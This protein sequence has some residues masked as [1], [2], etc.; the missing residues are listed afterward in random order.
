MRAQQQFGE[1]DQPGA[2][3]T[4]LVFGVGAQHRRGPLVALRLDVL[5]PAALVLLRVDPPRDLPR[6][7]ARLVQLQRLHH[8]LDQP[9]LVV[10]V[11]YLETLRQLR[12]PP[13]Q[14]QQA[15]GDAVEGADPHAARI[16]TQLRGDARAHLAGRL[17][18]EGDR[19]DAVHR[20]A[21]HL[22]Q[23]GDAVGKHAGLAGAGAGEDKV[24]TG[25]SGNG[26][27]L[28]RVQPVEQVGNIHRV[29]LEGSRSP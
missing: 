1:I 11:Q 17:V 13:V 21:E 7:E 25:R 24:M 2:F 10:A 6:R 22:V 20:H 9:Q 16:A 5:R 26:L 4:G 28:G 8:A 14:A 19:E 3:A 27:A 23:P 15:M 12:V 18:G 29:S